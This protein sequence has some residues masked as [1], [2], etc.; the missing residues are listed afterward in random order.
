[1]GILRLCI[2]LLDTEEVVAFL[3][4]ILAASGGV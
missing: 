4:P 3:V 1:M 2:K